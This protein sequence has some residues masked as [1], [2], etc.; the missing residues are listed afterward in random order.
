MIDV[1]ELRKSYGP[2][3]ALDGISFMA[4]PVRS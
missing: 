1:F 2:V 4:K 3:K